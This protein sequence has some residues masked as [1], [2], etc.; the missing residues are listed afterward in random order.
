VRRELG[1]LQKRGAEAAKGSRGV[2]PEER[3]PYDELPRRVLP[4]I[5]YPD[6]LRMG[7]ANSPKR[8]RA[9]FVGVDHHLDH[10]DRTHAVWAN[11]RCSV[12]LVRSSN[13]LT[14]PHKTTLVGAASQPVRVL[15]TQIVSR[16]IGQDNW[17]MAGVRGFR[18]ALEVSKVGGQPA[19]MHPRAGSPSRDWPHGLSSTV[20]RRARSPDTRHREG[21]READG[22]P[23]S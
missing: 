13:S 21:R 5:H 19:A 22:D 12:C 15:P 8:R 11:P 9:W 18:G 1:N 10:E 4:T 23:A 16:M 3:I 7:S 17:G 20:S 6:Y 14:A 2:K